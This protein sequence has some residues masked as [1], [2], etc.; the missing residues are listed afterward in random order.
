MT[1]GAPFRHWLAKVYTVK[2]GLRFSRPQPGWHLLNSPW[3]GNTLIIPA[4]GE[5]GQWHPAGGGKSAS[6]FLSV[7]IFQS[8]EDISIFIF[9]QLLCIYVYTSPFSPSPSTTPSSY[10]SSS[11][12]PHPSPSSFWFKTKSTR[13]HVETEIG[14]CTRKRHVQMANKPLSSQLGTYAWRSPFTLH[15]R[16]ST[17]YLFCSTNLLQYILRA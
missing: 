5:F 3:P 13:F 7:P 10:P 2:K 11:H 8:I 12:P 15:L 16:L 17:V 14:A 6:L 4:Q 9:P 1:Q